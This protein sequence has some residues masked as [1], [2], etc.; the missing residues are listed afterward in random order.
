MDLLAQ[1]SAY[2]MTATHSTKL[3]P[4]LPV[5]AGD[6]FN[7]LTTTEGVMLAALSHRENKAMDPDSKSTLTMQVL[8]S[9]DTPLSKL[10]KAILHPRIW[11]TSHVV[12]A[13]KKGSRAEAANYWGSPQFDHS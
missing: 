1:H 9:A 4:S 12:P 3:P 13:H 10:F 7:T 5:G 8:R 6:R 2:K 11:K